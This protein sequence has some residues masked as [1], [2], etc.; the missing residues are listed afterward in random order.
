[1]PAIGDEILGGTLATILDAELAVMLVS[2][3]DEELEPQR[4][5]LSS[6]CVRSL[7]IRTSFSMFWNQEIFIQIN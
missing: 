6:S 1:M 4:I 7:A 3:L 2:D 5:F